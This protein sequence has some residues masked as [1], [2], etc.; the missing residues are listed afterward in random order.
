MLIK[1]NSERN[2]NK[3]KINFSLD[4]HERKCDSGEIYIAD[5]TQQIHR[6]NITIENFCQIEARLSNTARRLQLIKRIQTICASES[7]KD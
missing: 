6:K 7:L 4:E 3:K 5:D 2:P 1:K